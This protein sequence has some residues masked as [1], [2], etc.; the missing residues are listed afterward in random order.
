MNIDSKTNISLFAVLTGLPIIITAS[1][2]LYNI[3]AKAS[4]SLHKT[5]VHDQVLRR[6][7]KSL[8][9]IEIHNKTLKPDT[10]YLPDDDQ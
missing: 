10:E 7:E 3:D 5:Q 6:M 4:E 9:R 8:V 2:W 1:I